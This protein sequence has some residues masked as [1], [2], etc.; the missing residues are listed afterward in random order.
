MTD[1]YNCVFYLVTHQ[2]RIH[3]TIDTTFNI[4]SA[5]SPIIED[6][7]GLKFK[8]LMDDYDK[9]EEIL[10]LSKIDKTKNKWNSILDFKWHKKEKSPNFEI[11]E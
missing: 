5:S 7:S 1:C 10:N 3:K 8:Q 6:C 2:L 4:I 11:I 9:L